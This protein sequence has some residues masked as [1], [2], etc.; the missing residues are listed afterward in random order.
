MYGPPADATGAR[1]SSWLSA[2]LI[3]RVS[4]A[5]HES[6]RDEKAA[7]DGESKPAGKETEKGDDKKKTDGESIS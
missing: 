1:F 7:G 2:R 5:G 4:L 6:E 3:G